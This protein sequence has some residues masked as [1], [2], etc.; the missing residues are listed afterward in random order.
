MRRG[1]Q[2]MVL[3]LVGAGVLRI[4]LFGD[5]Y[6]RYVKEGLRPYL[7]VA[8]VLL[9][10]LGLTCLVRDRRGAPGAGGADDHGR[11]HDADVEADVEAD[12]DH[13]DGHGHDHGGKGPRVAWLLMLPA[14]ALLLFAPP[15]LGSYTAARERAQT[16]APR[17]DFPAL[18]TSDP[19]PLTLTE[20]TARAQQDARK[21]LAGRSV[22]LTGFVTPTG[23]GRWQLTRLVV[24]C[25]AADSRVLKVRV[26]GAEAPPA[27]AWVTIT[28]TWHRRG[29]LGT[30]SAEVGLDAERVERIEEPPNQY[31]DVLPDG[32]R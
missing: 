24:S 8:G 21:S 2:T 32:Q 11:S 25:C 4:T 18:P 31:L 14:L 22:R 16:V 29:T 12:V 28:G 19:V 15:A 20:F 3:L 26:H 10:V 6:L 7:I 5:L 17:T 23:K 30:A 9:V 1:A 27:D 13:D